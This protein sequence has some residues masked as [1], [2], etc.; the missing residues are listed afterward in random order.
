MQTIRHGF[1]LIELLIVVVIIGLL[2]SI[3]IPNFASIRDRAYIASLK[4]DLHNLASL[5]DVY[6]TDNFSYSAS[7]AAVDFGPSEGVT[8]VIAEANNSGW[9]ASSAHAALPGESCAF[10]HGSATPLTPATIPSS[11]ICSR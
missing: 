1:T 5:Q 10:Y 9:S 11:V 3:A 6:Y 4:S 7:L 2:A 8:V